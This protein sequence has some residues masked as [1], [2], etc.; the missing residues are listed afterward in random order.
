MKRESDQD[1][2]ET[3]LVFSDHPFVVVL[4]QTNEVFGVVESSLSIADG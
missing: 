1:V 3:L 2:E 4:V